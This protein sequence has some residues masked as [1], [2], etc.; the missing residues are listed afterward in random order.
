M[1]PDVALEDIGVAIESRAD[2]SAI[3][4]GR[5]KKTQIVPHA[6]SKDSHEVKC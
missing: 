3:D 2:A 6:E 1:V 4:S 5:F